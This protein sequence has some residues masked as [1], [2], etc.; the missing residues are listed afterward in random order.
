MKTPPTIGSRV[1][2][3]KA[4][5]QSTCTYTGEVPF[6]RGTV[7]AVRTFNGCPPL[8]TVDWDHHYF[9][10]KATNVLATNLETCR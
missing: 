10:T 5:L 3:S 4:W 8:V 7:T 2:F 6:L 1:R 9:E